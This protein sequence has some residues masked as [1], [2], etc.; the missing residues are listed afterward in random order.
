MAD[1]VVTGARQRR[2]A[3]QSAPVAVS[4]LTP[5]MLTATSA[6]NIQGLSS[7]VPN[8][9]IIASNSVPGLAVI[10]LR[11]FNN[12]TSDI[13]AEPAVAVYIDGVYQTL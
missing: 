8:L 5:A 3:A 2:E 10:T 9:N 6:P 7:L 4:V 12:N 1:I 11:G 13:S